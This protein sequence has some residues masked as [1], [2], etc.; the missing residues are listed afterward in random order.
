MNKHKRHILRQRQRKRNVQ[1]QAPLPAAA[2]SPVQT[3]AA[4]VVIEEPN[5]SVVPYDENLLER[6]RTQ[7]QFGDWESLAQISRDSLQHH[8][9]RAKLALLAAAGLLQ[10]GN[11]VT[12]RQFVH[13]AQDWGCSKKLVSQ[14]LIAGVHN[15]LGRAAVVGGQEKRALGH[16]ESAVATGMPGGDVQLLSKARVS[17]QV[18]QFGSSSLPL[19]DVNSVSNTAPSIYKQFDS[20]KKEVQITLAPTKINPYVHNRTLSPE[21]NKDLREFFS[22]KF[23]KV[24]LKPSYIDYL[25]LKAIEIEKKCVGRL[26]TT[27]QDAVVRQIVAE[28]VAAQNLCILE[29]G[30][31][32]GVN[33]AILY[34]DCITRFESVKVI[35]LDPFEGFYGN[36]VDAVLNTPINPQVFFRNMQIC[37]IPPEHY[38]MIRHYSTDPEALQQLEGECINLLIIDGDHSYN[39]VKFDFETY[40]PL[41]ATGGYVLFD[42]YNA[43]EWPGVQQFV[44]ELIKN[45]P[46]GFLYIGAFSR[47]ALFAKHG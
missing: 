37:N 28:S 2:C 38:R 22:D 31:L 45:V 17:Y 27:I 4:C 30:S 12:A 23:T 10:K 29:I 26:A 16:F 13:L 46:A 32:Y 6:S 35:G 18:Q 7:W 36:A 14:I 24:T 43:K 34:N 42:D 41:L 40:S 3:E 33:L 5:C 25:A 21:L 20:F 19:L 11:T 8:P 15:S 44:D 1:K 39:G 47:T 9:D